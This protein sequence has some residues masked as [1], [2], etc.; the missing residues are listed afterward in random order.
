MKLEYAIVVVIVILL[1]AYRS[2]I[3]AALNERWKN[4][5]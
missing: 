3:T 5:S 1:L 4:E 2:K